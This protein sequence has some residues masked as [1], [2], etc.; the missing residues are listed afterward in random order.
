MPR[1]VSNSIAATRACAEPTRLAT[2]GRSRL[3]ST[4]L[5]HAPDG[6]ELFTLKTPVQHP[7]MCAFAGDD[8]STLVFTSAR[9]SLTDAEITAQPQAG[10]VFAVE[11]GVRGLAERQRRPLR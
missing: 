2:R 3:P 9:G 8:L 5:G 11:V 7:T 1:S 10:S 6:S 4:Q